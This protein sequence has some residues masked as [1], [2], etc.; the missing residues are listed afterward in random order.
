M[1]T[2]TDPVFAEQS[3]KTLFTPGSFVYLARKIAQGHHVTRAE[4]NAVKRRNPAAQI[5]PIVLQYE[6]RLDRGEIKRPGRPRASLGHCFRI[7]L[8]RRTYPGLLRYLQACHR[9][10]RMPTHIRGVPVPTTGP[11]HERAAK[12]LRVGFLRHCSTR[13]VLNIIAWKIGPLE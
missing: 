7:Y 13:H 10:G 4:L 11:M 9:R 5:P 1:N 3:L 6:G 8:V 12:M 2:L